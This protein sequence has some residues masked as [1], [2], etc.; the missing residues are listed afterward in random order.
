MEDLLEVVR[1]Y[2]KTESGK[3]DKL[4]MG[5]LE[6]LLKMSIKRKNNR[7]EAEFAREEAAHKAGL[8]ASFDY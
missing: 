1:K 6:D 2:T 5:I 8:N 4:T 3:N 7:L